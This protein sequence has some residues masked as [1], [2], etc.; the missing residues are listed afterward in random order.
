MGFIGKEAEQ[1]GV[2]PARTV[3]LLHWSR[4]LRLAGPRGRKGTSLI[5]GRM[6]HGTGKGRRATMRLCQPLPG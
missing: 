6:L 5:N 2:V 1:L 3:R 4:S